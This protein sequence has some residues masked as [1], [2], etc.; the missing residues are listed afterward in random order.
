MSV[1]WPSAASLP[2]NDDPEPPDGFYRL[3]HMP[4]RTPDSEGKAPM[5]ADSDHRRP[6]RW[7]RW[8]RW[9]LRGVLL[10]AGLVLALGVGL[11]WYGNTDSPRFVWASPPGAVEP[12]ETVTIEPVEGECAPNSR[13]FYR[14]GWFGR[15]QQTH[16]GQD[17][18]M[19]DWWSIETRS[20]GEITPCDMGAWTVQVPADVT[21]TRVAAC[22]ISSRCVELRIEL[23]DSD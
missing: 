3:S 5:D 17:R 6:R 9:L 4:L 1:A 11:L 13:L 18:D 12:G 8:L 16:V 7:R 2:D 15:W 10:G 20:Y 14:P 19:I 21:W 22:D 23:P